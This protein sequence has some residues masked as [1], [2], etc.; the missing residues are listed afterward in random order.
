MCT[1][2]IGTFTVHAAAAASGVALLG[3]AIE[4]TEHRN[5]GLF[6]ATI[7]A[8][9]ISYNSP[10][11]MVEIPPTR[12]RLNPKLVTDRIS[13]GLLAN[14]FIAFILPQSPMLGRVVG[15]SITGGFTGG[16]AAAFGFHD[17][18]QGR[19]SISL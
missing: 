18:F 12:I 2:R 11:R 7:L 15:S 5:L 13:L 14:L 8:Q 16:S 4:D 3:M 9:V 1:G 19:R 6:A 10:D 17:R